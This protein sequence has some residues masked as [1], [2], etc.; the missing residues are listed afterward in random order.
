MDTQLSQ[1]G[2]IVEHIQLSELISKTKP[3]LNIQDLSGA[4]RYTSLQDLGDELRKNYRNSIIADLA[5]REILLRREERFGTNAQESGTALKNTKKTAYI[6]NQI[7]HPAEIDLFQQV[8]RNNFY[9]VGLLRTEEER[10]KNLR[11]ELISDEQITSLIERDRKSS[12]S[13]G[14][15]VEKCLHQSDFFIKKYR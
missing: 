13:N 6:V 3:S 7:K 12:N 11:D 1:H 10:S 4:D 8:Y 9:L 2:Y 14:Q 15:Q 5:V